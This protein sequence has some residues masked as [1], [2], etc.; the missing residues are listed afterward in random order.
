MLCDINKLTIFYIH[1]LLERLTDPARSGG[2]GRR[3]LFSLLQ[4]ICAL[5]LLI[6]IWLNGRKSDRRV[7]SL[8][9][10]WGKFYSLFIFVP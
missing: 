9:S 4:H 3:S 7:R 5:D 6:Q 10:A 8:C 2:L 1:I